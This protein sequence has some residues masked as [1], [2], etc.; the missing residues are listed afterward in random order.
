MALVRHNH[1]AQ[2]PVTHYSALRWKS[3]AG[4]G[5]QHTSNSYFDPIESDT[6]KMWNTV[7]TTG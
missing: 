7:V 5:R 3:V 1:N 4:H 6:Y 2:P